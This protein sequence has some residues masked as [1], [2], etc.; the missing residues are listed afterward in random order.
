MAAAAL[1]ARKLALSQMRS[2]AEF[3][4]VSTPLPSDRLFEV[5]EEIKQR[6][7]FKAEPFYLPRRSLRVPSTI[8]GL[9]VPPPGSF[10]RKIREGILARKTV[11]LP[12]QWMLL[13]VSRRPDYNSGHQMYSDSE[14]LEEVLAD[15]RNQGKIK[16]PDYR[17][18]PRNSHFVVSADEIDGGNEGYVSKAVASI[19]RLRPGEQVTTP[20]YVVFNYIGNLAHPE[21][22]QTSTREW[23]ADE[24]IREGQYLRLCGGHVNGGLADVV[25]RSPDGHHDNI[26]FRLQVS[27]PFK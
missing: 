20:R 19:L 1:E 24:F 9:K 18:V 13:D 2:I 14:G 23:F 8:P 27:F 7:L 3:F 21:F 6:R 15:L 12:G 25:E 11:M 22:G 17:R 10:Y 4:G 16:V 5:A 26:G